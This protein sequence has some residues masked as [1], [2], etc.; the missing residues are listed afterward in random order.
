[1]SVG[2]ECE[3]RGQS[4]ESGEGSGEGGDE[5]KWGNAESVLNDRSNV[6][7]VRRLPEESQSFLYLRD[8]SP[9]VVRG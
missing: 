2:E 6:I 9:P 5:G 8:T 3:E 7:I 1:M 4:G